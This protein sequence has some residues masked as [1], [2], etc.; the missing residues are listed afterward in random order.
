[1]NDAVVRVLCTVKQVYVFRPCKSLAQAMRTSSAAV[2]AALCSWAALTRTVSFGAT[3]TCRG[4]SARSR[5]KSL[6]AL[7]RSYLSATFC[8][9]AE[10]LI[11]RGA[12]PLLE[13]LAAPGLAVVA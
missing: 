1:M 2:T 8:C 6:G 4:A 13:V 7:W 10:N 12:L 9:H 5:R 11:G 3:T